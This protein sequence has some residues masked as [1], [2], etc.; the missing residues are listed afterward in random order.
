MERVSAF[1]AQF[2]DEPD[3]I[4]NEVVLYGPDGHPLEPTHEE[5]PINIKAALYQAE[6]ARSRCRALME[7]LRSDFRLRGKPWP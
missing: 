3:D 5:P 2:L 7:A 6:M 4:G 1:A